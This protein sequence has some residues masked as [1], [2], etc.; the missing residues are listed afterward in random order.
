M[1]I[2]IAEAINQYQLIAGRF[3]H[4]GLRPRRPSSTAYKLFYAVDEGVCGQ[5]FLQS[6]AID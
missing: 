2:Y 5:N 3:G 1:R 6:V 4:V